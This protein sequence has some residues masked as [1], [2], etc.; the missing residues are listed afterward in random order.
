MH[1]GAPPLAGGPAREELTSRVL[2]GWDPD[3][4]STRME[5]LRRDSQILKD[6]GRQVRPPDRYR[7]DLRPEMDYLD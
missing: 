4:I 3:E 7:W 6:W 1:R 2:D 5:E